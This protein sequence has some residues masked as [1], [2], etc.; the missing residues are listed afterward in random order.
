MRRK[1]RNEK[2]RSMTITALMTA[3]LCV[4]CPL[5]LPIGP[6]PISLATLVLF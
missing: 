3:L 6:V 4:L 1:M 2:V 5:S